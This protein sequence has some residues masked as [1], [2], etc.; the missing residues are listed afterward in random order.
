[1]PGTETH[2]AVTPTKT[3]RYPLVCTELCGLGHAVM[4]TKSVVLEEAAFEKWAREQQA[5]SAG[6]SAG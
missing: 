1:V 6:G 4:R 5:P 2:V 3:G